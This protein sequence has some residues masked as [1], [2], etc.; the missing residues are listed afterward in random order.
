MLINC[1]VNEC[2]R[3]YRETTESEISNY[4]TMYND[5]DQKKVIP[6]SKECPLCCTKFWD[7]ELE[8]VITKHEDVYYISTNIEDKNYKRYQG[9]FAGLSNEGSDIQDKKEEWEN[10]HENETSVICPYCDYELSYEYGDREIP[11]EEGDEDIECPSCGK[12]FN[13]ITEVTY[14]YTTSKLEEYEDREEE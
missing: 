10:K 5:K 3:K 2:L 14:S 8:K 12:E 4:C 11:Y 9:L 7:Y 13:C 6:N 1:N